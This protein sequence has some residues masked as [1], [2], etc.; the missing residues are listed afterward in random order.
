MEVDLRAVERAVALVQVVLEAL[1]LERRSQGA[2]GEVPLLVGSELVLGTGRQLE[3]CLHAEQVVEVGGV[4]EAAEDLVLDLIGSAEDVRV[5]LGDVA[6][7]QQPVERAA[8]LV[9]VERGGLREADRELAIAPEL[10]AEEE[11]VTRAVHRLQ[12]EGLLVLR[13]QEH[14]VAV[15]LPVARDLPELGVVDERRLHLEIAAPR[16]LASA[17]ILELVPDHHAP[18]MPERRA[19]RVLVEVDEVELASEPPV[20]TALRLLDPQEI[21]RRDPAGS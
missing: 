10:A 14:V 11:H 20:V 17:E 2:F 6:H 4:V 18:G 5:V 3:P 15:L 13:D 7:A 12:P 21:L 9:A 8:R 19:G 1:P 16:V